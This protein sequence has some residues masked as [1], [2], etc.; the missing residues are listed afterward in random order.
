MAGQIEV[1]ENGII[2]PDASEIKGAFQGVFTNAMGTDLNLDDS[3]PQGVLIDDLT[4]EKQLD[5]AQI[6]YLMNQ[7]NPDTASGVFQDAIGMLY[8][9]Q[10]KPATAS[11][12]NCVCVGIAGTVLNGINTGNP[13]MAQSVNGDI[14]QCLNTVTIPASGQTSEIPF[15]CTETGEKPVG[16]N[17]VNSIYKKVIGW[18]AVN[19]PNGGTL[20]TEV[21]SREAFEERRKQSLALNA[22][23]S[24]SAVKSALLNVDG[25][26]DVFVYENDGD[27]AISNY[28]GVT[29]I[30]PHSIYTCIQ[31]GTA[32][33]IGE[34]IYGSKSA[35]CDTNGSAT[36]TYYNSDV[37]ITFSYNYTIPNASPIYIQV[38]LGSA[39]SDGTKNQIMD[40]LVNDFYGTADNNNLKIS[41]GD[42]I[43]ASRFSAL[44]TNLGLSGLLLESVKVSKNGTNWYDTLE[45]DINELPTLTASETYIKFVVS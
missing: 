30:K 19:N 11:I 34:A 45:T 3:T 44:I 39:V 40:A 24:L 2:V 15:V 16:A 4:T 12:A 37:D 6:L 22:T 18:D 32:E 20:G 14:F 5:N 29:T 13:A 33:D 1:N 10:R 35:G 36:A 7:L 23:G 17:T 26:I 31:G 41:I 25:V 21:E 43:Y 42:T 38:N 8:N 28:R 27:T 9:V